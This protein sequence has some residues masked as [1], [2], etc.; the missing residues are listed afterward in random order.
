MT[1]DEARNR[2][3][4]LTQELNDHNYLYYVLAEPKI[5][6]YEFDLLLKEL[7]ALEKEHP[8]LRRPDS[9]TLRV[10]GEV[11]KEFATVKHR[12]PM[13]SLGNTYNFEELEE[14][15]ARV[16]KGLGNEA[17]EYVCEL[18]YDGVA[19]GLRYENGQLA[20]AV[21]RGDGE[22]GDDV[23]VNAKTIR[24]LPLRLR[25]TPKAGA[26][27]FAEAESS[28][29]ADFE[30][31]GEVFMPRSVFDAINKEKAEA[32]EAL[33]ANPR[34]SAAGTLKMQ[35]S[36]VVAARKLECYLYFVLGENLPFKTHYESLE[37]ARNWGFRV[38]EFTRLVN[39]LEGVRKFIAHWDKAR[40][41]LDFDIDGIVIKVNSYEQ[42]RTLGF[43]AKSPR[44][45]IS[46]KFKAER[47]ATKL[48]SITYQ[49]GRT[50]A[51]T[52]VANLDPVQLAG[53]TVKR[54]SLHNADIIA[55]LDVRVG[56]MVY[57]EKG[58][59][60][61]PKIVG[62]ELSAR[63]SETPPHEYITHCPECNT[64]LVREEGEAN[65]YCPNADGC[66]PQV[67]GKLEHFVSRRAMN[68]DSLGGE[69][70][71]QLV[72]AGL[73]RHIADLYELH[74]KRDAVLALDRMAEKS[75]N[76]LLD[77][78]EQSKQVPF[79]RVLFALGIRHVGETTARKLAFHF[80]SID[81][82]SAATREQLLD[83][84]E[85]GEILADSI[86]N[87]FADSFHQQQLKKLQEQGLQFVLSEEQLEGRSDKLA[88]LTFVISG[89]FSRSRDDIKQLIEQ[90]GGK[91]TGS[92][93]GKTSYLVAGE[94]MGPEKRAKAEKLGVAILTEEQLLKLIDTGSPS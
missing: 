62:V 22:K 49:V 27:L 70:L 89:V 81:A 69:T 82:M 2:I 40:H 87:W 51:I 26:D 15:D 72:E 45:A 78:I 18:K 63:N 94:S 31:R 47:V 11:T 80:R 54:A 35:D 12:Y 41:E 67:L 57:V 56:D 42:Q 9:P 29:P 30:I 23:T 39:D 8:E 3:N 17:F 66:G 1:R 4:I 6:D 28:V 90:N 14:F 55:K 64:A 7:E 91:N 68:I 53:T 36:A 92:V 85:V 32:G 21:T 24:T 50:G 88:G 34:N 13:L 84:P 79:E 16:R 5:S 46:Y 83:V 38:P 76:N 93:S 44:W 37:A 73:I 59:E 61:I 65:H 20:Q 10:G 48:Q 19:I 86:L 75:V 43:T 71:A 33:L 58:G 77:G 52:P 60:I 25:D 74:T